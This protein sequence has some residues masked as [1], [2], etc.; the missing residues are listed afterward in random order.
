METGTTALQQ[1]I[2]SGKPLLL[3]E[4]S[5]PQ[6]SDPAAVREVTRRLVGKVHAVGISDNRDR[7][8]MSALAAATLVA[9][10]GVEPILH[11]IT[12][13]RNRIALVSDT[14]G[15]SAL[16]IRNLL[17]TS[18]SHQTL[19]DFRTARN[20]FDV[21]PVQMLQAFHGAAVNGAFPGKTAVATAGPFCLG[22]VASPYADP[23]KLQ[24]MRLG[25]KQVA[26]ARFFITQPIHD[27][28]RFQQWWG[29]VV[30][31]GLHEKAAIVAG[32]LP[33][34]SAK[35]AAELS[36]R[37]PSPRIPQAILDRINAPSAAAAQHDAGI[38]TA[39]ETIK[40]LRAIPGLR[41]FQVCGDGNVDAVLEVIEKSSLRVND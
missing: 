11:V 1:R 25:K 15:A 23:L 41:G 16:G 9:A 19:G 33:L 35:Q 26:G 4:M 6:S 40:R 34:T 29:E 31:L 20:V 21:D 28:E 18:G 13:D 39:V 22:A 24:M 5:P 12:R 30:R 2:D 7:V 36:E 14:L 27:I 37:R 3:A 10:E 32:I 17:C 8:A 38:Q